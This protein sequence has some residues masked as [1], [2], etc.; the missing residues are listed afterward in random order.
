MSDS[1]KISRRAFTAGA[2][3]LGLGRKPALAQGFAG[4]G[5][6]GDGFAAVTPGKVFSF[7]ADH[8]PHPD[9]RIEWWYVTANL[10]GFRQDRLRRAVDAVSPGDAAGRAT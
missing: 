4:L 2:A 9:F 5:I 6:K 7:P 1:F 10:Q 3:L 8:G